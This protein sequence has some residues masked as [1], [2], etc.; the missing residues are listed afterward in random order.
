M[1]ATVTAICLTKAHTQRMALDF[2]YLIAR[3]YGLISG[4]DIAF[5]EEDTALYFQVGAGI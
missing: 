4:I 5:S 3:R 2:R 1:L